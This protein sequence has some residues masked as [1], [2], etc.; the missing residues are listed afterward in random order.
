MIGSEIRIRRAMLGMTSTTLATTM[1]TSRSFLHKVETGKV[2][3]SNKTLSKIFT[4]FAGYET[5]QRK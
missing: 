5:T 4:A 1:N 3:P 2:V